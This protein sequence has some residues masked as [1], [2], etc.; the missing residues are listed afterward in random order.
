MN[1]PQE[2]R[3]N[4]VAL[5]RYGLIADL[6]HMPKGSGELAQR[7]QQKSA[8]SYAIPHSNRVH[9]AAETIR[10]WLRAYRRGGFDALKPKRRR[11]AGQSHALPREVADLLCNIKEESPKFSV[12]MII[13]DARAG[14]KVPEELPLP[15]STVH[16]LLS[17]AGLMKR[18]SRPGAD[19]RKFEFEH[20][21]D[22]WMTDVMHGPSVAT[23]GKA[24]RKAYMIT[25]LD[26]STRVVVH[27]AFALSENTTAFLQVLREA[28][29]RRGIPKRLYAD[30]GSAFR[31]HHLQLVCAKLGITLINARAYHPEGKGKIERYHRRI[32]SQLLTRLEPGDT[33]N[34]EALNR[35][36]WA[37][38]ES[39]YHRTPHKGLKGLTPLD[40]WAKRATHVE[41]VGGCPKI[42]D[43]FLYEQKRKVARDRTVSLDGTEYEV[44]AV[45][46]GETVLLRFD[47][48]RRRL[49]QVWR[50]GKRYTDAKPVDVH[51]NTRVKRE[52][53]DIYQPLSL[54]KLHGAEKE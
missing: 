53:A 9:V 13:N 44:D 24:R 18:N 45:L 16:R 43:L 2:E 31:S 48:A 50:D 39:E 15:P 5:F 25:I 14:G 37:Y 51:A 36:L 40:A 6:I 42:D 41:H 22:L 21:N 27:A 30:N 7:M 19:H 52:S 8:Q 17:R 49:V 35:R 29:M 3:L 33:S 46:V 32:R 34:L 23:M 12:Q 10:H 11:D 4:E 38:L 20:A 54:A 28:V 1:D 47:P 26:D